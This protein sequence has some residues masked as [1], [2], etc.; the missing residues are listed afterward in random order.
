MKDHKNDL[1]DFLSADRD[2]F[3]EI[4]MECKKWQEK[5]NEKLRME[6]RVNKQ[7]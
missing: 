3:A 1:K 2:T 5:Q 4:T 6:R 7:P